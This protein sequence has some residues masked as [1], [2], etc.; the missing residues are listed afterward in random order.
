MPSRRR[1]LLAFIIV[2]VAASFSVVVV[3]GSPVQAAGT[4]WH[5]IRSRA[6]G[7]GCID[8]ATDNGPKVQ[9]WSCV[10]GDPSDDL[11]EGLEQLWRLK[12][13][14]GADPMGWALEDWY[15]LQC[16]N[17]RPRSQSFDPVEPIIGGACFGTVWHVIYETKVGTTWYQV[18]QSNQTSRCLTAPGGANGTPLVAAPCDLSFTDPKQQ[19]AL[20]QNLPFAGGAVLPNLNG[21]T[22][23]LASNSIQRRGLVVS[24]GYH[25]DCVAPG[26]VESQDPLPGQYISVGGTVHI[27][28]STCDRPPG[29]GGG[30]EH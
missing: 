1:R 11:P 27:T 29:G 5:D 19:W 6:F 12:P 9:I 4:G 20:G 3:G 30:I 26:D 22:E 25:N 17:D 16:F 8:N 18:F 10:G 15:W 21:S 13:E 2:I 28:V 23:S 14:S 7:G 24:T